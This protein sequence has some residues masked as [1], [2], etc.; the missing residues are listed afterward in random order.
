MKKI[1]KIDYHVYNN[2]LRNSFVLFFIFL[3]IINIYFFFTGRLYIVTYIS[4]FVALFYLSSLPLSYILHRK[5][6]K[7]KCVNCGECCKFKLKLQKPDVVR[8]GKGK[9]N[10]KD[11]V[12]K[13]WN[14]KRINGYCAFLINKNGKK[15]CSVYKYSPNT[16]RGWPF[17]SNSFSIS[18]PWFLYCPSLRK[19]IVE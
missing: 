6:N 18:W 16:C 5:K 10:W 4:Y 12:D 8:F 7:F 1:N 17:F 19:L 14:V 3:A 13:N 15:L 2:S 11:F 9:V